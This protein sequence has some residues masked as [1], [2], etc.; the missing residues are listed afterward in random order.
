[1]EWANWYKIFHNQPISRIA[2]YYGQK[3][4]NIINSEEFVSAMNGTE[5][6]VNK[7]KFAFRTIFP[8]SWVL[9]QDAHLSFNRG[10]YYYSLWSDYCWQ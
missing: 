2:Q 4:G 5:F 1:M 6:C 3:I 9:H 8:L 10:Y 7:S